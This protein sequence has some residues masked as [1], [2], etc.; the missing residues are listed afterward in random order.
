MAIRRLILALTLSLAII[1]GLEAQYTISGQIVGG[2]GN[3]IKLAYFKGDR[4]QVFDSV[5]CDATGKFSI[6]VPEHLPQAQMR[7]LTR[8]KGS[9]EFLYPRAD[10]KFRTY[11]NHLEDSLVFMDS[12]ENTDLR[13]FWK[14]EAQHLKA[15]E[16]LQP[17]LDE[18]PD[19]LPFYQEVVR[20]YVMRQIDFEATINQLI[21]KHQNNLASHILMTRRRPRIDPGLSASERLN[22]IKD[23][24]FDLTPLNDTN[25]IYTPAYTRL[26]IEYLMLY[27]TSGNDKKELEMSLIEGLKVV[28]DKFQPYPTIYDMITEYLLDG[29]QT[30]GF[31]NVVQ[32]I[33]ERYALERCESNN[34]ELARRAET[35]RNLAPGKPAPDITGPDL[36]GKRISLSDYRGKYVLLAFWGS[37]CPHCSELMPRL[38]QLLTDPEKNP[39]WDILGISI[40][41]EKEAVSKAIKE[42]DYHFRNIFDEKGWDTPAALAYGVT[43]T[44]TFVFIDPEGIIIAK[45]STFFEI[46]DLLQT[47]GLM[48]KP[49]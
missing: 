47:Y 29:F 3:K 15:L 37:W 46:I 9:L 26:V 13:N 5:I 12:P 25:L 39:K 14:Y 41:T 27:S 34:P 22:F 17:L 44:P 33:S 2:E 11:L 4:L 43:A 32:W 7:L 30:Y 45:P 24:Y 36:N 49:K 35:L 42:K 1:Q 19:N 38:D 6:R 23:H 8:N 40:D 28:M 20:E 16:L 10:V 18:Y 21:I 48:D 31:E